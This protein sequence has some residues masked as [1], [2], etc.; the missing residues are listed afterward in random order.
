MSHLRGKLHPFLFMT[1]THFRQ[2]A[3]FYQVS[4]Q[5]HHCVVKSAMPCYLFLSRPCRSG[6]GSTRRRCLLSGFGNA[7]AT[8]THRDIFMYA[9]IDVLLFHHDC[10]WILVLLIS[11]LFSLIWLLSLSVIWLSSFV[12]I[13]TLTSPFKHPFLSILSFRLHLVQK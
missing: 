5:C 6:P 13:T 4:K 11:L 8:S 12:K 3:E 7:E 10:L 1:F 2:N 9:C